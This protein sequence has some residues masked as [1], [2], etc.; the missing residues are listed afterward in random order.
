MINRKT[1]KNVL[2][3]VSIISSNPAYS[4]SPFL[5]VLTTRY[6]YRALDQI[7]FHPVDTITGALD[8]FGR[9]IPEQPKI[10]YDYEDVKYYSFITKDFTNFN[11]KCF[12]DYD[13]SVKSSRTKLDKI[14]NK[15]GVDFRM[16]ALEVGNN[17]ATFYDLHPQCISPGFN[18]EQDDYVM[19]YLNKVLEF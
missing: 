15:N 11:K 6:A 5:T 19:A 8:A 12:E 14:K 9:M 18:P 13:E 17:L 10:T 4:M 7:I 16:Q 3:A 2:L 1:L